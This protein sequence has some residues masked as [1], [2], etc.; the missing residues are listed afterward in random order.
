MK[1]GKTSDFLEPCGAPSDIGNQSYLYWKVILELN[2]LYRMS[3]GRAVR[4]LRSLIWTDRRQKWPKSD[5]NKRK[6]KQPRF[7]TAQTTDANR[8]TVVSLHESWFIVICYPHQ[9][10]HSMWRN[11]ATVFVQ[12]LVH[13]HKTNTYV[14]AVLGTAAMIIVNSTEFHKLLAHQ[15][16]Q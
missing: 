4:P 6:R 8:S 3:I 11:G 10:F 9:V 14:A 1:I 5:Y 15:C 12:N 16:E 13:A 7:R 2:T